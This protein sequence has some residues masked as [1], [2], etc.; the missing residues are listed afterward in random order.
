MSTTNGT[1]HQNSAA[2]FTF[3]DDEVQCLFKTARTTQDALIVRVLYFSGIRRQEICD[4]DV[5]DIQF[6]RGRA[7]VRSGNGRK[8]DEEGP[9]A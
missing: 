9:R 5:P 3:S 4:L 1:N 7:V 8:P 2:E 6:D